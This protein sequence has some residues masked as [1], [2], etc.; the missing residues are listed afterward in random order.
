MFNS[1]TEQR[2]NLKFLVKF[3]LWWKFTAKNACQEPAFLNGTK[4]FMKAGLM[5]EM[6]NVHDAQPYQKPL[7]II[8]KVKKLSKK[9]VGL[10]FD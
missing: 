2:I 10:V 1:K 6:M 3:K 7:T 4:D 9:M 8:E 5:L